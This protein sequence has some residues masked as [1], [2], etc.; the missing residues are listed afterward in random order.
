[1]VELDLTIES[2]AFGG[3]G[4]ARSG[5][6]RVVF[7]EGVAPGD[8]VRAQVTADQGSYLQARTLDV[9]EPGPSRVAPPCPIVEQC[10]GCPWQQ[11]DYAAQLAAK[12]RAVVDALERIGAIH[13]PP[14]REVL[15]SPELFGYR[16]RLSLRFQDARIGFYQARTNRLVPVADCLLAEEPIRAALPQIEAFVASLATRVM[17]VEIATRGRLPGLVLAIQSGGRLR[18][19]DTVAAQRVVDEHANPI[20]GVVMQGRGW[21]RQW[22]DVRRVFTVAEGVDVELPGASFGQVNTKGNLLLVEKT[23]Q[24]ALPAPGASVLELYAGAGN[25][26]L[27]LARRSGRLTAVDED[28]TAVETGRASARAAGLANVRFVAA[29]AGD[30]LEKAAVRPDVLVV[31]PPRSGLTD[32]AAPCAR[33]GAPRWVYVSC[34]PTTLARDLRIAAEH[35]YRLKEA[36]P[37]DMFPHTFHVET[38]C[39]LELT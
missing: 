28:R 6:G 17:R 19:G 26:S 32:A 3:A 9:L 36:C 13:E 20:R 1:M 33:L 34:N 29:R 35:G 2:L 24:A 7:V 12:K 18:H 4:V 10:G 31:D 15:P 11:V 16:N 14:V 30:Y 22:G 38:V 39:T 25:F 27:A 37:I 8:R 5:D 21:R 23:V